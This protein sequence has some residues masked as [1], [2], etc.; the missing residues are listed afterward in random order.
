MPDGDQILN[1]ETILRQ[2]IAAPLFF[3]R[4]L[5]KEGLKVSHKTQQISRHARKQTTP[6]EHKHLPAKNGPTHRA[7]PA[8]KQARSTS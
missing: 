5:L 2:S 3:L 7:K 8:N 1:C 4:E 6:R